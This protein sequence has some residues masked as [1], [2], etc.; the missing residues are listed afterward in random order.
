M[1]KKNQIYN[2]SFSCCVWKKNSTSF[3]PDPNLGRVGSDGLGPV[4]GSFNIFN[5]V[6][7]LRFERVE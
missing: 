7:A 2:Y 5:Q 4:S 6:C 1:A 3:G